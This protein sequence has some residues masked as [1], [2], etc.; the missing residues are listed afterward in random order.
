MEDGRKFVAIIKG[1]ER[2]IFFY[3]DGDFE[4]LLQALCR[5]AK[6]PDLTFSWYDAAVLSQEVRRGHKE[7]KLRELKNRIQH[8]L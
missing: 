4:L 3:D 8:L 7:M 1:T 5:S 6:D 2:Y